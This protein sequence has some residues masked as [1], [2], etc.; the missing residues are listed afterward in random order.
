MTFH[1]LRTFGRILSGL[2]IGAA[3]MYLFDP[4]HGRARRGRLLARLQSAALDLDETFE[5]T[6]RD[7]AH[8]ARGRYAELRANL[9][10]EQV[11]DDV[12]AE[13][14]RSRLG[15]LVS[16]PHAIE[17]ETNEGV[18][19]VRGHC[20]PKEVDK[21]IGGISDVRGVRAIDCRLGEGHAMNVPPS[22]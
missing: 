22:N 6:A 12:L 17:V 2:G 18:V 21:L 10:E 14:V 15:H 8:R 13:R 3:I 5:R 19:V 16:Y 11:S 7:L 20:P 4:T 1:P 9:V